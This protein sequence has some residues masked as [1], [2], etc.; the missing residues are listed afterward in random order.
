MW[1][2]NRLEGTSLMWLV[3]LGLSG[4]QMMPELSAAMDSLSETVTERD[5]IS[6]R[7][8]VNLQDRRAQIE[9]GNQF[10]KQL[11]ADAD[12]R[13]EPYNEAF[14]PVAYAR[15]QRIFSRVHTVSH[16]REEQWTPVLIPID[17]FNAFT[18]GGTYFV[19][20]SG[21]EKALADD[22]ELAAVIAH[23]VA[24]VVAGH[25]GES[26]SLSM[27]NALG[28]SS[29]HNRESY[30]KAF[31]H[32]QE[33]EADEI[34]VLYA[35]LAGFDP[36]AAYHLWDRKITESGAGVGLTYDHPHSI[37]RARFNRASAQK[38]AQYY[39]R[40]AI[41]PDFESIL[42]NN[43]LWETSEASDHWSVAMLDGYADA[44]SKKSQARLEESRQQLRALQLQTVNQQVSAANVHPVASD[45][46]RVEVRYTGLRPLHEV[47]WEA[48]FVDVKG[49]VVSVYAQHS[50]PVV[51]NSWNIV[52]F[53]DARLS[54]VD[55]TKMIFVAV[56][57]AV[58]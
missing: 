11:L 6:G 23:E 26:R 19:V 22:D 39:Q 46:I 10:I 24:H 14:D 43:A 32:Q 28:N 13:N 36:H 48:Q 50:M 27:F 40:D 12:A 37:E 44:A 8:V 33:K 53:T 1:M 52:E 4:C 31:T 47:V 41:N 18:T 5:Q 16:Y 38:L 34:A 9:Q 57:D 2:T 17:E 35:A 58:L 30:Q 3:V 21:L 25:V 56:N 45:V 42:K 55:M 15:I 49:A 20:Y 7:R 54:G 29:T 51:P